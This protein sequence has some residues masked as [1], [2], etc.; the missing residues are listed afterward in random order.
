MEGH[1]IPL[2]KE[3]TVRDLSEGGV[4]IHRPAEIAVID[5]ERSGE[6][7]DLSLSGFMVCPAG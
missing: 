6:A 2:S 7:P 3:D 5:K 1:W 4:M